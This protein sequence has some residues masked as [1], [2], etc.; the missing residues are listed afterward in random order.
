MRDITLGPVA[1]GLPGLSWEWSWILWTPW[2]DAP[3]P[4]LTPE[5]RHLGDLEEMLA[6]TD[7]LPVGSV[8]LSSCTPSTE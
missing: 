6:A 7:S 8:T 2:A 3:S 1:Q 4:K 5:G